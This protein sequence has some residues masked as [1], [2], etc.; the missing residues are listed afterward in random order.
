MTRARLRRT[1]KRKLGYFACIS[2]AL[3]GSMPHAKGSD[4]SSYWFRILVPDNLVPSNI[5]Q[6]IFKEGDDTYLI[7]A[8]N[9]PIK[10]YALRKITGN[11]KASVIHL[12]NSTVLKIPTPPG[13]SLSTQPGTSSIH[14]NLT[15]LVPQKN[16]KV[17]FD[18][19]FINLY[20]S[21]AGPIVTMADPQTGRPLLVGTVTGSTALSDAPSGPGYSFLPTSRGI[22]VIA[23]SDEVALSRQ[24]DGFSLGALKAGVGLPIG[25]PLLVPP[26]TAAART[27]DGLDLPRYNLIGLRQRLGLQRIA[28][29]R[30]PA[31]DKQ[32]PTFKLVRVMLAL[33]MGPE[34]AGAL[35]RL[36]QTQPLVTKDPQWS[37]L[38]AVADI[39]SNKPDSALNY[40]ENIKSNTNI[41]KILS[42]ISLAQKGKYTESISGIKSGINYILSLPTPIRNHILPIVAKSLIKTNNFDTFKQY[43]KFFPNN[44]ILNFYKGEYYEKSG[45]LN[46]AL[47]VYENLLHSRN[48]MA[49]GLANSRKIYLEYKTHKLSAHSAASQ[50]LRHVYDWRAP[51][52]EL[53]LRMNISKL[54]AKAH[55]WPSAMSELKRD[56]ELFPADA[57][58]I[59]SLREK[60]FSK[61]LESGQLSKLAPLG[62]VSILQNNI[63]LLPDSKNEMK[64]VSELNSDLK[65]LGLSDNLSTPLQYLI[66]KNKNPKNI[67]KL[68]LILANQQYD[69]NN[70]TLA[71][72]TIDR[73]NSSFADDDVTRKRQALSQLITDKLDPSTTNHPSTSKNNLITAARHS[74]AQK[75]WGQEEDSLSRYASKFLRG[76][77]K[78]NKKQAEIIN[79]LAT[80]AYKN[81]DQKKIDNLRQHYLKKMPLGPEA[82]LFQI[83]TSQPLSN[84]SDLEDAINKIRAL[85][86]ISK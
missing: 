36:A 13:Q 63:D 14:V 53:N 82:A 62:A 12:Q 65:Q 48:N 17:S 25:S 64:A 79:Q 41:T 42:G 74:H 6:S 27:P 86:N 49:F 11:Q 47:S 57:A 78:L 44:S 38:H 16:V 54:Y 68:G 21:D 77:S 84:N 58:T 67:S 40:L 35:D 73:T 15:P 18:K 19:G 52:H 50:L 56:L 43:M 55:D 32:E 9:F 34:A 69:D 61:L 31:L 39:I 3:C 26:L 1:K 33:D 20:C 4:S 76:K 2:L 24:P 59:N 37:L 83:I 22:A 66:N 23:T 70:F 80:A 75:N 72:K 29:T 8:D 71:K 7:L 5:G 81:N 60:L 46:K 51:K 85:E 30:A 28:V 10:A 45:N